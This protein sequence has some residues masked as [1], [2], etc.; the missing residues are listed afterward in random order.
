VFVANVSSY[1]SCPNFVKTEVLQIHVSRFSQEFISEN[2]VKFLLA[3]ILLQS[4][5]FS[6]IPR[7]TALGFSSMHLNVQYVFRTSWYLEELGGHEILLWHWFPGRS[8]S[9]CKAKLKSCSAF[10]KALLRC[11]H[12]LRQLLRD[13]ARLAGVARTHVQF[14]G[15]IRPAFRLSCLDQKCMRFL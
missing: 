8:C 5:T 14:D 9:M 15:G 13:A 12:E 1:S 3:N 6:L 7:W 2:S 10:G 4:N 11:Q